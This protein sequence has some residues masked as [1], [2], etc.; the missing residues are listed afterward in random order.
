[1]DIEV[2]LFESIEDISRT[3]GHVIGDLVNLFLMDTQSLFRQIKELIDQFCEEIA[4]L[5]KDQGS[6]TEFVQHLWKRQRSV[7]DSREF[8]LQKRAREWCENLLDSFKE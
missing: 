3:F 7:L 2:Q 1:M 6:T 4:L 8:L 5:L